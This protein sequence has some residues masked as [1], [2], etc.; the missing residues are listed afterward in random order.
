MAEE[1]LHLPAALALS[2][3]EMRM[4]QMQRTLWRF[5]DE[6]LCAARLAGA[7]PQAD[8][9][10]ARHGPPGQHEIA[11][12]A[13]ADGHVLLKHRM[14]AKRLGQQPRLVVEPAAADEPIDLLEA[15]DVGVFRLDAV[16]DPLER[17]AAIPAADPFVDVP[18][19]QSHRFQVYRR[20]SA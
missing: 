6:Q 8:P 20:L 5:D 15:D 14:E 9:M 3:P 17:V 4:H 2:E 10:P 18:A 12:G 13:A 7:M 16:D 11:V 19:E 1:S